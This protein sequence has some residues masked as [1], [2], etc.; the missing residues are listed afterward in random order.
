[1]ARVNGMRRYAWGDRKVTQGLTEVYQDFMLEHV[2]GGWSFVCFDNHTFSVWLI[3]GYLGATTPCYLPFEFRK[4]NFS[5][6][7]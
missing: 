1:M 3:Y 7:L 6:Y 2:S 5:N 4:M